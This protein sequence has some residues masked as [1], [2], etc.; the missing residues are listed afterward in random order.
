MCV[1]ICVYVFLS[2]F[3]RLHEAE[4]AKLME[5]QGAERKKLL[6]AQAKVGSLSLSLSLHVSARSL[7][8]KYL[9]WRQLLKVKSPPLH[10]ISNDDVIMTS[11]E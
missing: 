9:I 4:K 6:E 2:Q 10:L 11:C 1:C 7:F 8:R 5:S 3:A